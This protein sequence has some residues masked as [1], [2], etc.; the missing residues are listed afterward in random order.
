MR[1]AERLDVLADAYAAHGVDP[2]PNLL[3]GASA[4]VID[5]VES[6]LGVRFPAAY[7]ELYSWSAGTVDELGA[8]PY[9]RF[10]DMHLLPLTRVLEE[11]Q[12]LVEVYGWFEDLDLTT[13]AP[14]A[15]FMGSTLAVACGP[16]RLTAVVEHPVIGVF[17]DISVYFDS[18]E[19]MVE[20]SIAWVSQPGWLPHTLVPHEMGIWRS[21]NRAVDF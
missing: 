11:R 5:D 20:T 1:L 9:L 17:H 4:T 21:N 6:A 12:S 3:P 15:T 13:V 14:L 10:R 2:R 8:G 7:R 16:Q 19:A 18:I